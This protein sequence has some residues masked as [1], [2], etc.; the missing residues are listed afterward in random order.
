MNHAHENI[1]LFKERLNLVNVVP[2][3]LRELQIIEDVLVALVLTDIQLT[4]VANKHP[5][6][7]AL[8][9]WQL[10]IAFFFSPDFKR[11]VG[12]RWGLVEVALDVAFALLES[13]DQFVGGLDFL[14]QHL[15]PKAFISIEFSCL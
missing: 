7:I 11:F 9:L 14:L 13:F 3:R 1:A 6:I 5:H 12:W 2:I 4:R 10:N 15:K 8:S